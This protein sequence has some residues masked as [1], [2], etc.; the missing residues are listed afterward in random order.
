MIVWGGQ[1]S[2]GNV[3]DTNDGGAYDPLSD[4][5][6]TTSL[7]GAPVRRQEHAAV[8]TGHEMIVWGGNTE[9]STLLSS[10]GRYDPERDAWSPTRA[11]GTQPSP[12]DQHTAVWTGAE[13][14]V[15]GGNFGVDTGAR[16]CV[17]VVGVGDTDGDGV[18]DDVDNCPHVPNPDQADGDGDRVG[19]ACDNCPLTSN[20]GQSDM[21]GDLLGDACDDCVSVSNS[22][23]ADSDTDGVG[24][25]CDNCFFTPNSDQADAD[26]DG[27]GDGCDVCPSTPDPTQSDYDGDGAGDACDNCLSTGNP[28]QSDIDGDGVGDACDPCPTLSGSTDCVQKVVS[29]CI[30]ASSPVGKGSGT[31]F[32][33][34][35]FES[36]L[37]GFNIVTLD[38]LG[39]RSQ[40]NAARISCEACVTGTG[41]SYVFIV[42]KHKSGKNFYVESVRLGGEVDLFGPAAKGCPT[43]P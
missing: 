34:T 9:F 18:P 4:S 33:R 11:D 38:A 21:D 14:I 16:Y 41:A 28:D 8:W 10:G 22:D 26:Q 7:S 39:T 31:I 17:G 40:V 24:D 32:W 42:P 35:Q 3:V 6:R 30:E 5:W 23:Q 13:M 15:W 19:D 37:V 12:R 25:V 36:D 43:G 2:A 29:A 27:I 1:L 20:S